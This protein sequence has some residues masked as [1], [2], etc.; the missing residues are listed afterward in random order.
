MSDDAWSVALPNGAEPPFQVWVNGEPREEG[1][2]YAVEGRWLRFSSPLRPKV[3]R[4]GLGGRMMLLAGIGEQMQLALVAGIVLC[5]AVSTGL[6]PASTQL[7]TPN[8]LRGQATA[9]YLLLTTIVGLG[10]G[11]GVLGQG[12]GAL[13]R[14]ER[15]G[16]FD[17]VFMSEML[18]KA[19]G[20]LKPLAGPL[21]QMRRHAVCGVA[22]KDHAPAPPAP[23]RCGNGKRCAHPFDPFINQRC[24][25]RRCAEQARLPSVAGPCGGKRDHKVQH[26][27]DRVMDDMNTAA[28]PKIAFGEG[29]MRRHVRQRQQRPHRHFAGGD[30]GR[31]V[32]RHMPP[33]GTLATIGG[34][35]PVT[36]V[37]CAFGGDQRHM[38]V[39]LMDMGNVLGNAC[40][41]PG[42]IQRL[43]D[44]SGEPPEIAWTT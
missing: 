16:S 19:G 28:K 26:L 23:R 40:D 9:V 24:Q 31:P 17:A 2:D 15:E 18:A 32:R 3:R 12:G 38:P 4:K 7:I 36:L 20:V 1:A 13:P 42:G 34:D 41:P 6:I 43:L 44:Q 5:G 39:I 27:A 22:C 25:W 37:A 29:E 14:I 11:P 30:A 10:L 33:P 35:Q 8:E 21:G